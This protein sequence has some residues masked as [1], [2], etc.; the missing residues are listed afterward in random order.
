MRPKG[1]QKIMTTDDRTEFSTEDTFLPAHLLDRT[2][3][4][5]PHGS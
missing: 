1:A 2:D 4:G 3:Q 5:N